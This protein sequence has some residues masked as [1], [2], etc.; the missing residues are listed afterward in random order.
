MNILRRFVIRAAQELRHNPEARAKA[1][2]VLK[3][4]VRPR[5]EQA[6]REAQPKIENAKVGLKRFAQR[7]REEYRKG[8][9][10][11]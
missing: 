7:V 9:D 8:R 3:E 1:S 6:W 2:Q 10:G 4:Q 5:A 11:E